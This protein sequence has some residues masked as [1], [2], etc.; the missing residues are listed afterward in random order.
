MDTITPNQ[1]SGGSKTTLYIVVFF[2]CVISATVGY[3]QYQ[4]SSKDSESAKKLADLQAKTE[5]QIKDAK[6]S[7]EAD[8][9]KQQ[10]TLDAAKIKQE[11]AF[12]DREAKMKAAE[13]KVNAD[14]KKAADTV[15]NAN[16]LK[17]AADKA[18][19]D[20][21]K[22]KKEAD[23]AMKKAIASGNAVDKK[24]ADEKKKL[25]DEANKKVQAAEK[26]AADE[27]KKAL[28][29]AKKAL[30]LK[31]KLDKVTKEKEELTG[32]LK[33]NA[34]QGAPVAGTNFTLA[35]KTLT[36]IT[37]AKACIGWAQDLDYPMW[38]YYDSTHPT[39]KN[40]CFGYSLASD[41]YKGDTANQNTIVACSYSDLRPDQ[42]KCT[43]VIPEETVSLATGR[44]SLKGGP[45]RKYCSD[46]TG[47]LKCTSDTVGESEKFYVTKITDNIYS[48]KGGRNDQYCAD[49]QDGVLRCNRDAVGNW[50]KFTLKKFAGKYVLIGGRDSQSCK[51][52]SD[53]LVKCNANKSRTR[54][55]RFELTKVT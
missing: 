7:L 24:L 28:D 53:K 26:K 35:P 25:A 48:L 32:A 21:D 41:K 36:N 1:N 19:T 29:E 12:K 2:L 11:S 33:Y 20:A 42:G 50:E 23:D 31:A 3:F 15:K 38:G 34:V 13:A 27:K 18:K 51:T 22:K 14:L 52:N 37:D 4:L 9:I 5:S 47:G 8:K 17:A 46:T 45:D 43:T 16:N 6:T 49:D 39:K 10:A 54:E 40:T 55:A 30:D 44:Y